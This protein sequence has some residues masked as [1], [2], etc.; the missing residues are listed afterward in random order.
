MKNKRMFVLALSCIVACGATSAM[1][2]KIQNSDHLFNLE[3]LANVSLFVDRLPENH[4]PEVL[5]E[6]T[7]VQIQQALRTH[8]IVDEFNKLAQ[9]QTG[10]AKNGGTITCNPILFSARKT[11]KNL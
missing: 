3:L 2:K 9:E 6:T 4:E 11:E 10:H 8:S 5:D 1:Q 7:R